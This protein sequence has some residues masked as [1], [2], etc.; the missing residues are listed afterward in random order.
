LDTGAS[1][2]VVPRPRGMISRPR[3][4]TI[5][6]SPPN[7]SVVLAGFEAH[8][9]MDHGVRQLCRAKLDTGAPAPVVPRPRGMS[10]APALLTISPPRP[11]SFLFHSPAARVSDARG[12][13]IAGVRP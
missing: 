5:P 11:S 8:E 6:P 10:S 2:P 7:L 9:Q 1:A 3:L 13:S 4:I 12:F